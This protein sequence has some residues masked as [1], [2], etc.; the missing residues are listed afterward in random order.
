MPFPLIPVVLAGAALVSI[1]A[2][3]A[4]FLLD[5]ATQE[6]KDHQERLR[7]QIKDAQA[8]RAEAARQSAQ[9]KQALLKQQ[10]LDYQRILIDELKRLEDIHGP[11]VNEI[12]TLQDT[13][14]DELQ[15]PH[16]NRHRREMLE[17]C[18]LKLDDAFRRARAH[19]DYRA[20]LQKHINAL[21][22]RGEHQTLLDLTLP[23]ITLPADWLYVGKVVRIDAEQELDRPLAF[24]QLL[25][26]SK[27]H[28]E[29]FTEQYQR[30][31]LAEYPDA[32]QVPIQVVAVDNNPARFFGCIARGLFWTKY[33]D[34]EL[35]LPMTV[36]RFVG[37]GYLGHLFDGTLPVFLPRKR[38]NNPSAR[39]APGQTLNVWLNNH[40]LCLQK[41]LSDTRSRPWVTDRPPMGSSPYEQRLSLMISSA[42]PGGEWLDEIEPALEGWRIVAWDGERRRASLLQDGLQFEVEMAPRASVLLITEIKRQ[43]RGNLDG[44]DNLDGVQLPIPLELVDASLINEPYVAPEEAMM[45]F[46]F[47]AEQLKRGPETEQRRQQQAA[48]IQRWQDVLDYQQYTANEWP[49]DIAAPLSCLPNGEW[50]LHLTDDVV[51]D[52]HTPL[53]LSAWQQELM[54]VQHEKDRYRLDLLVW[55]TLDASADTPSDWQT[56]AYESANHATLSLES[57]RPGKPLTLT[58][59]PRHVL[60]RTLSEQHPERLQL[61]LSTP[62]DSLRRQRQALQA[63]ERDE[64]VS[65]PLKEGLL[66]PEA[67]IHTPDPFWQQRAAQGL[68]W[69]NTQLTPIQREV[70]E[71]CLTAP[72]L[73]LVQGPPG[74]AKTTCIVELLH[75]LFTARSDLRVLVVSQQNTAVDNALERFIDTD[76]LASGAVKLVRL[77]RRQEK[78]HSAIQP[79]ALEQRIQD[80]LSQWQQAAQRAS[81]DT[82]DNQQLEALRQWQQQIGYMAQ[83]LETADT[84]GQH[85]DPEM[86]EMLLKGHNLIGAT[87]VGLADTRLGIDRLTF[88]VAIIDEA[89]RAT[90]PEL[91]IPLLRSRKAILIGDHH[92]L[93][94]TVA[95]LLR[96]EHAREELPF[97]SATFLETS[98]F[99]QLFTHLPKTAKAR[100]TEQFRMDEPI[101]D[102]VAALFYTENG[103]RQLFNGAKT[104]TR[105]PS[106]AARTIHWLQ[107]RGA[108]RRA[109]HEV[110]G[111]TGHAHASALALPALQWV[112]VKGQH[113][114]GRKNKSLENPRE[115]QVLSDFLAQ[116]ASTVDAS[117][118]RHSVAVITPYRAQV[119]A[120]EKALRKAGAQCSNNQRELTLGRFD[121]KVDTIDSF[122]GSEAYLVCYSTVRTFGRLDFVLDKKR[123]NV[124]CSR[125]QKHLIF[126]GDIDYLTQERHK[127]GEARNYFAEIKQVLD[128]A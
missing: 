21:A 72:H 127:R 44:L 57:N 102:L 52:T 91:L 81:Q 80:T 86:A 27:K 59:A 37:A 55:K 66:I 97:L 43:P 19:C 95:P 53:S 103:E 47:V 31:F 12:K 11:L 75:Q 119:R 38:L 113:R 96:E 65:A 56:L 121:V 79:F 30:Q 50:Q 104:A 94:P 62:D 100:L 67:L 70:I 92:Q 9:A 74:T 20:Y 51:L 14:S 112:P 108:A 73:A 84:P 111:S 87:C 23:Q 78:I 5:D 46:T 106:L 128:Q 54:Q 115:A 25:C 29:G 98:F 48:F 60:A 13:I 99:E 116:H 101:G 88:D 41:A 124:A 77:G 122:Q 10:A 36:E 105:S 45:Q 71:T 42:T 49:L 39:L 4:A 34:S 28:P 117:S 90:V 24:Q 18:Q 93:P 15:T 8:R 32:T 64:I 123:L 40:D 89:A 61:R 109:A 26:L 68:P 35:P 33:K 85:L 82:P 1:T 2:T 118:Q 125:A 3:C 126:F 16:L 83:T 7:D 110:A 58:F 17:A 6:E 76:G 114:K 120:I 107:Q 22:N 69:C 63:F